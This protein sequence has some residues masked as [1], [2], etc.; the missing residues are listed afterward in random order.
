MGLI[1]RQKWLDFGRLDNVSGPTIPPKFWK[2]TGPM[3]HAG[4][5][6]VH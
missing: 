6:F 4:G 5:I 3:Y 2:S 1:W